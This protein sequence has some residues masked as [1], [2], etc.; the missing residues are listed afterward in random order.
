MIDMNKI[1][2]V[3]IGNCQA[4]PIA[5]LLESMTE[6][7][8]VIKVAIVHL[9]KSEQENEYISF[10][11]EA[12]YIIA[13]LVTDTYPCTFVQTNR[14]INKYGNKVVS[15][16][17]IFSKNDTPY[18]ENLPRDLR[19]NSAPFG[20]Y[21][22]PIIFDHWKKGAKQTE[23]VYE[24]K[25][26][27]SS[28]KEKKDYLSDKEKKSDIKISDI[29]NSSNKRL[30]HTF[31][32]PKNEV[33]IKYTKRIIEHLKIK[34]KTNQPKISKEY[35]DQL[36]PFHNMDKNNKK[37]EHKIA[38]NGNTEILTTENLVKS[39]YEFY[40]NNKVNILNFKAYKLGVVQPIKI[41]QY[42]DSEIPSDVKPLVDSWKNNNK[43]CEHILF[44]RRQAL[45]FMKE[46]FS[47]NLYHSAK[48]IQIPAMFSDIFR[49]AV[50]Y[51][52]G[53]VYADC[54]TLCSG[55]ISNYIF[56]RNKAHFLRKPNGWIINGVIYAPKNHYL[57]KKLWQVLEV[58]IINKREGNIW[59]ITGPR[60]LMD[61]ISENTNANLTF[62]ETEANKPIVDKQFN[63][64]EMQDKDIPFNLFQRLKHKGNN[65]WSHLQKIIT[66]YSPLHNENLFSLK[67][68]IKKK[69]VIH[70]GQHKTGSTSIQNSLYQYSEE[71]KKGFLYPNS[72]RKF[73]GHHIMSDIFSSSSKDK[74]NALIKKFLDESMQSKEE[75]IIISSEYFSSQNEIYFGKIRMNKIWSALAHL[76]KQFSESEVIYYVRDQHKSIP[77]RVNQSIKSRLCF[78]DFKLNHFY[79]N[80]TLNYCLFDAAIKFY[81]SESTI[82]ARHIDAPDH[83]I[84]DVVNDFSKLIGGIN[85][86]SIQTNKSIHNDSLIRIMYKINKLDISTDEKMELKSTIKTSDLNINDKK[87]INNNHIN[88]I[89]EY[90]SKSNLKFKKQLKTS[91]TDN[92]SG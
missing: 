26:A 20:D 7:V 85:L 19:I 12:D 77:S 4:R 84:N 91:L 51:K 25:K 1:K 52:L 50:I 56:D 67:N 62:T 73:S 24:L 49:I 2:I 40:D 10:F 9:L 35:L 13:Q 82:T 32:H 17:N 5:H 45:S 55:S 38:K 21:H 71:V 72:G 83:K 29:I 47:E 3:V 92:K 68:K 88:A 6:N 31:N 69:L 14:L 80:P 34:L 58:D 46:N 79:E 11:N 78:S 81:F 41:I 66:L 8:E 16:V 74:K 63:I 59:R 54:G 33:L 42:W 70:I 57:I 87:I 48:E 86:D 27:A 90:Y 76:S 18:L 44:N 89:I 15:I 75:M 65:H 61:I 22:F 23:A 28:E 53:G 39:F 64:I 60:R 43:D 37:I 30:F 36:V